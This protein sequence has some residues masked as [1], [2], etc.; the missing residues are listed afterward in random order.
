[1]PTES[2]PTGTVTFLFTDIEGSTRLVQALGSRWVAL[3]EKHNDLVRTAVE[4]NH[5]T[6]VKTEGD[7]FFA[8]FESALEA[9]TA[10]GAA[11][12]ALASEQWPEDGRIRVRMGLHTGIGAL[13]GA[14]YVGL[15]VHRAARIADAA[16]GGQTV[17]SEPT[18]ILVERDL[19]ST[20]TLHDLG[21]HRLK[22]LSEPESIFELVGAGREESFPHLRTL[23]AIPNNLPMQVTSFV[24]REKELAEALR[25]LERTRI[26][27]LTGPGGTGKTRLALQVAA[28]VGDEFADG[29]FFV[30]LASVS[31]VDVVPSQILS[32]I[33]MQAA[34][35]DDSPAHSLAEHL[36]ARSLLLILDNFEQVLEAAPLVA[37]LVRASSRSK[38]IV[39][40]RAPL[41]IS[42]EQ[43]MPVAPLPI[44]DPSNLNDL[45]ALA[46]VASIEL[47]TE[48]AIAVRPDF[49]VTEEN[50]RSVAELVRRLDGLPLAIELV[51]SRLR[52]L[53]VSTILERLD[54]RMLSSGSVDLPERQRTIQGAITW[55]YDL[56]DQPSR[57]LFS[58]LSVFA[59]GGRLEEI[60]TVCG[61]ADDLGI[62]VIEGL[63]LLLDQ[64]LLRRVDADDAPRFQMLHVIREY[65]MDCLKDIGEDAD[66]HH[67]HLQAYTEMAETVAPELLRKDRRRWLD[68]M[69]SDHDNFRMALEWAVAKEKVDL[70]LRLVAALWRFW[71]ARG[72]LHEARRRIETVLAL[73]GGDPRHRA[74]AMEALAGIHWWQGRLDECGE[75][76]QEVLGLQREIGDEKEVANALY[77]FSLVVSF[78]GRLSGDAMVIEKTDL[79]LDEAEEIYQRLGD[80][81]GMG[82]IQWS[83]GNAAAF[84][85]QD[86]AAAIEHMKK[87]ADCYAQAGNEF[88]LGWALFETGS[89]LRQTN[90]FTEGWEYLE[91]GL[92]LF[93][94]HRDVSAAVLFIAQL[95]GVANGLGDV[96]RARRLVGAFTSLQ[97]TS[98]TDLVAI[99]AN[100]VPG[101]EI[102][103]LEALT[104]DAAIPY[105]EGRAMGFDEA[106]AYALAG[107]TDVG[108][109]S[110]RDQ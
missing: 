96:S 10:S 3:L 18:A 92:A 103:S 97:I 33:G 49:R 26:L 42:G 62:D 98:G 20:L 47:F 5:G 100:Q 67:R 108:F 107:P 22:D 23:D 15:D 52:L 82:D 46:Q 86:L 75:L 94:G 68:V 83:R 71:Q 102:A 56:L 37:D 105:R 104:G 53:P 57:R 24:G 61:P 44:A 93:S 9:A 72:H 2:L 59:G 34:A 73:S 32:S 106:V 1:M 27:T 7:S 35:R 79:L 80:V 40:S 63:G 28:E 17:L 16:H 14:D 64:S 55:S 45:D 8:V 91:R 85:R 6:V 88:G 29:V 21:K 90:Q 25:L 43:E 74:K 51:A 84:L 41:Q 60:E 39:T 69:E 110:Q 38:F 36:R 87:S 99:D 101:M 54:A 81:G 12:D 77:N 50:A 95:A 30:E 13:G 31:D 78:Q 4:A 58:R 65:A 76:Y 11:Q 19:P 109:D 89:M 70:A 48:R 66:L